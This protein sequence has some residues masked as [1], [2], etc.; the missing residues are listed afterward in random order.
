MQDDQKKE[1]MRKM[2]DEFN[3]EVLRKEIQE[4]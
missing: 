1:D 4:R 3:M 2:D